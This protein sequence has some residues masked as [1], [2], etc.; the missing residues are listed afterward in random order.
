MKNIS[1]MTL[2]EQ[3]LLSIKIPA[4]SSIYEL[5][6]LLYALRNTKYPV[7]RDTPMEGNMYVEL[8]NSPY[9][10]RVQTKSNGTNIEDMQE[11]IRVHGS[12]FKRILPIKEFGKPKKDL[13]NQSKSSQACSNSDIEDD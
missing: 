5:N 8:S 2:T 9:E 12:K 6:T 11:F 7:N 4:N 10:W 1:E 13:V 3:M